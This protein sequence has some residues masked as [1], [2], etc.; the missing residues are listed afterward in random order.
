[1]RV[2]FMGTPEFSATI[3]EYL[4]EQHEVVAVYTRPDAVRG[5]GKALEPS[6][7]KALAQS[8]SIPVF[9]PGSLRN[10]EVVSAIA[11]E[12]P[13]VIVVAAYGALLPKA[14]LEI[15]RY[16]C[17]N[18][19]ASLLP[20]PGG[21]RRRWSARSPGGGRGD[22]RVHHGHGGGP[23]HRSLLRP[24]QHAGGGQGRPRTY[25]RARDLRRAGR[26]LLHGLTMIASQPNPFVEQG[27]EGITYAPK[28]EKGE[29]NLRMDDDSSTA[30]RKVLASSQAHPCKAI[31]CGR[32]LTVLKAR[33]ASELGMEGAPLAAGE[34]AVTGKHVVIG[35]GEG[36]IALVEVKP[37]GRKAMDA[38]AFSAGIRGIERRNENVGGIRCPTTSSL[39][40][41]PATDP[42]AQSP[43]ESISATSDPTGAS[44]A[45]DVPQRR[46]PAARGGRTV[47][48]TATAAAA[49]G[50]PGAGREKGREAQTSDVR[51]VSTATATRA[52]RRSSGDKKP[53]SFDRPRRTDGPA[54]EG[55]QGARFQRQARKGQVEAIPQRKPRRPASR[56]AWDRRA[57]RAASGRTGANPPSASLRAT[58]ASSRRESRR[59][60]RRQARPAQRRSRRSA[61]CGSAT[62]SPRTSSR[63]PSIAPI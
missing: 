33:D 6:P 46:E 32:P 8:L 21:V 11:K 61:R 44:G 7:V 23:R 27:E 28:I 39:T 56:K 9:T 60:S 35:F 12:A 37:D 4:A 20:S 54:S 49:A 42:Q 59:A 51:A 16:G 19:H 43:P 3:L 36:A 48:T 18:V 47:S 22:R 14:V 5:R 50:V 24:P 1:M 38:A 40:A 55:R 26:A 53:R 62:P 52:G 45:T 17:V 29:L 2:V 34:V 15:P 31:V 63:T 57:S 30:L 25:R 13:D 58:R 41:D 10:D